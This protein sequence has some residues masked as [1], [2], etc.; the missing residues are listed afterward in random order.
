MADFAVKTAC[1]RK[2]LHSIIPVT[3]TFMEKLF[4]GGSHDSKKVIELTN[5]RTALKDR[6]ACTEDSFLDVR[7]DDTVSDE[8][9]KLAKFA[10]AAEK[11]IDEALLESER[12]QE[13][14]AEQARSEAAAAVA[15]AIAEAKAAA[16]EARSI[17]EAEANTIAEAEAKAIAEAKAVAEA[18][19]AAAEARAITE[20]EAAAATKAAAEAEAAAEVRQIHDVDIPTYIR[21]KHSRCRSALPID[22]Q[23]TFLGSPV[24]F[25]RVRTN[26]EAYSQVFTLID[27]QGA[28]TGSPV[29]F[30]WVCTN[31]DAFSLALKPSH[32]QST[33]PHGQPQP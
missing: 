26:T 19:A 21:Q 5:L 33:T 7:L 20:A 8:F 24:T 3:N 4:S 6:F 30:R 25:R 32:G 11:A 28:L 14:A 22:V 23:G 31:A 16:A 10:M 1:L 13:A 18:E 17:A 2:I 27:M 15:K 9:D 29:T 12:L